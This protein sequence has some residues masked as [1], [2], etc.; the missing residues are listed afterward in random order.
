[1]NQEPHPEKKQYLT[2]ISRIPLIWGIGSLAFSILALLALYVNWNIFPEDAIGPHPFFGSMGKWLF[3]GGFYGGVSGILLAIVV[4][5]ML[6]IA[7]LIIKS[8]SINIGVGF[9]C[10]LLNCAALVITDFIVTCNIAAPSKVDAHNLR[11]LGSL[12]QEYAEGHNSQLPSSLHWCDKLIE[13]SKF[14]SNFLSNPQTETNE[15]LSKYAFNT[16]LSEFKLTELPKNTVLFFETPLAK[17]PAGGPELM[18]VNNH[19]IKGCFV[20]FADMHVAFVRVEDFNNLRWK[21]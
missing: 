4:L 17:N 9:E 19:P 3:A 8:H 18:S 16:N 6:A 11:E 15:P 20:L 21:P 2:I 13:K 14:Y 5:I 1:M 12:F 10:F 7:T